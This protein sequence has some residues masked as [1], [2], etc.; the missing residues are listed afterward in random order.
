MRARSLVA[1]SAIVGGLFVYGLAVMLL[2][3][4]LPPYWPARTAFF[5]VAGLIWIVPAAGFVRWSV[6]KRRPP[7][8]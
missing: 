4:L 6:G 8:R 1:I 5:A 3:E 2:A 7:S